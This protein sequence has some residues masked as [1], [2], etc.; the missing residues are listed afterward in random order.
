MLYISVARGHLLWGCACGKWPGN[1]AIAA[2]GPREQSRSPPGLCYLSISS[3]NS[4]LVLPKGAEPQ[5][6]LKGINIKCCALSP[7]SISQQGLS[8]PLQSKA[9]LSLPRSL[10]ITLIHTAIARKVHFLSPKNGN[11]APCFP[12]LCEDVGLGQ[13][14]LWNLLLLARKS[15]DSVPTNVLGSQASGKKKLFHFAIAS[16]LQY[17]KYS[18]Y[19]FN[20]VWKQKTSWASE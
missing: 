14:S 13:P 18:I 17:K 6:A 3:A 8:I 9:D 2:P 20:Q 19:S 10:Y 16:L 15:P 1:L 4:C 12:Y 11:D 7:C 5:P